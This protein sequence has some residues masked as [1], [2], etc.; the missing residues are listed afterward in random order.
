MD[1]LAPYAQLLSMAERERE[2]IQAGAWDELVELGERRAAVAARLPARPPAEARHLLERTHMQVA[3]NIEEMI[4]ARRRT[5]E[6]LGTLRRARTA[7]RSYA[8]DRGPQR[9]D[10][11]S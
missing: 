6:E 5:G 2:L 11:I 8:Q 9:I 3:A 4:A 7:W 1:E 10:A